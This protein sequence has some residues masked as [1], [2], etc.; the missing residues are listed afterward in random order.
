MTAAS[1]KAVREARKAV[2]KA[3]AK[4]AAITMRRALEEPQLL[5]GV[6][7]GDSWLAWRVMLIAIMGEKLTDG[8][9]VIFKALT[10]R[11]YEPGDPVEE[12]WAAIG[13][14][15]GKSRAM[16]VLVVYLACFRDYSGVTVAGEK[17][18]VL[19]LAQNVKQAGVS[20]SYIQ[21]IIDSV[22]LLAG[23]VRSKTAD[24]IELINDVGIEVRP[25]SFRGLRGITA[26]ACIADE[27]GFWYSEDSQSSN[28]DSEILAALR[29]AL[30]TT[31]GPLICISSPYARRGE[32]WATFDRH[33]G[34]KGDRLI[35]VAKA[36]SRTM[37]PSLRQSVIDRAM[38]RDAAAASAEYMAEFRSDLERFLTVEAVR[39]CV[40]TGVTEIAPQRGR[41]HFAFCDPSGGSADSMTLGIS[42]RDSFEDVAV[43]VCLREVKPPFSPEQTVAE[44]VAVLRSY[45]V[46]EIRSDRYGAEWVAEAFSRYGIR[47]KP[48]DKNRSEIYGEIL[49][50][51][52][53]RQVRLL[54]DK[55]LVAQFVGLER[56]T[57]RSGKDS[58]DHGPGAHD[59][60]CN[61]AAGALVYAVARRGPTLHWG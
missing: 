43:L 41:T 10:G 39:G 37:N 52:N 30:A 59:D 20:L 13:R 36:P 34:P 50:A 55:R 28:P 21:G 22:P 48:S 1:P 38:E 44:F 14:R 15:G 47:L 49:P 60:L 57:G 7:A 51:I 23:M 61:S 33:F 29:P 46:K 9:R 58:I 24:A 3:K 53:S 54:D 18:T 56:R 17:P 25:A 4:S 5:G 11:D 12:F 42:Y 35:L 6:L 19:L 2:A 16:A 26:V 45:G 40:M 32:L 27:I 8:E 31:G